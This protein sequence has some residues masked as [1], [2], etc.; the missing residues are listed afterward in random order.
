MAKACKYRLPGQETWMSEDDFKKS[1]A[2]GLLDKFILD[3]KASIPSLRGFK[4]DA[5]A[6]QKFRATVTEAAPTETPQAEE[7]KYFIDG[8]EVSKEEA[9][10]EIQDESRR[11]DFNLSGRK[12]EYQGTNEQAAR[13]IEEHNKSISPLNKEGKLKPN[14]IDA[15]IKKAFDSV[16]FRK[17]GDAYRRHIDANFKQTNNETRVGGVIGGKKGMSWNELAGY[18]I[19]DGQ[20]LATEEQFRAFAKELGL[21]VPTQ[22]TQ[23]KTETT[24]VTETKAEPTAKT[25]PKKKSPIDEELD[26]AI[27]DM[28][29]IQEEIDIEKDN[30]REEKERIKE[31]KAKVRA[32][33]MPKAEK[34]DKL[35]D[36]DAELQDYIDNAEGTIE[37]LQYDLRAAKSE[38]KKIENRKSK[39]ESTTKEETT[40]R[41]NIKR[42]SVKLTQGQVN[43][44]KR[45][46]IF[47]KYFSDSQIENLKEGDNVLSMNNVSFGNF[48]RMGIGEV[49]D[50]TEQ[51]TTKTTEPTTK[52]EPKPTT[53]KVERKGFVEVEAETKRGTKT[54]YM[55]EVSENGKTATIKPTY[56]PAFGGIA[57]NKEIPNLPISVDSKGNRY[58]QTKGET[59]VYIDKVKEAPK[60]KE[61]PVKE[62]VQGKGQPTKVKIFAR[63]PKLDD[64]GMPIISKFNQ[65]VEFTKNKRTGKWETTDKAGNK[66]EATEEQ[67]ARADKALAEQPKKTTKQKISDAFDSLKIDTKGK[68]LSI[69]IPPGIYNDIIEGAKQLVLKGI[70]IASAIKQAT[71]KALAARK[72]AD[73]V[74]KNVN[75]YTNSKEFTDKINE[76]IEGEERVSGIKKGL[77]SQESKELSEDKLNRMS[78]QEALDAGEKAIKDGTIDPEKIINSIASGSGKRLTPIETVAMSYYKVSLDND[79]ANAYEQLNKAVIDKD[80]FAEGD[81]RANIKLA[82]EKIMNYEIMSNIT[83]YEDG[84]TLRLRRVMLNSEYNLVKIR[85]KITAE[86]KGK[87]P[88]EV[89]E[90]LKDLD[91]KFRKVSA[92]LEKLKK[93]YDSEKSEDVINSIKNIKET[94]EKTSSISNDAKIK[95]PNSLIKEA[96]DKGAKEIEDVIDYVRDYVKSKYQDATDRQIRDAITNYSKTYKSPSDAQLDISRIKRIGRLLSNLEDLQ[97]GIKKTK[98]ERKKQA[99]SIREKELK[100]AIKEQLAKLPLTE[101]EI[102]KIQEDKLQSFKDRMQKSIEDLQRKLDKGD[103]TKKTN[104]KLIDLDEEARRLNAER[105]EIKFQYDKEFELAQKKNRPWTQ[106]LVEAYSKAIKLPRALITSIDLGAPFMQGIVF[107]LTQNP[108]TTYK[109]I[110]NQFKFW[111]NENAYKEWMN[112]LKSSEYYPLMKA[113]GL[114]IAEENA[115]LSAAEEAFMS[116]FQHKIPFLGKEIK[117]KSGRRIVPGLDLYGR[118]ERGY[119]GFLNNLRVQVFL[120]GAEKLTDLG[121][122]PKTNIKEFKSWADYV[123]NATMRGT[124]GDNVF[125]RGFNAS[126]PALANIFFSPRMIKGTINTLGLDPSM[127]IRLS[128]QAR[129]MAIKRTAAFYGMAAT[130]IGIAALALNYDDDDKASVELDMRSSDF[131]KIKYGNTRINFLGPVLPYFVA[132]TKFA[133]NSEKN[134]KTKEIEE[135]GIKY[136]GKTRGKVITNLFSNKLS[137]ITKKLYDAAYLTEAEKEMRLEEGKTEASQIFSDM[138]IPLFLQDV[139]ELNEEHGFYGATGLTILA[140]M[141]IGIQNFDNKYK[142]SKSSYLIDD[143]FEKEMDEFDKFEEQEQK[144][145]EGF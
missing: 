80:V 120:D 138:T 72:L 1:L 8:K 40:P 133:T 3:D 128:P 129:K 81:A 77:T 49:T 95:V 96:V 65:E 136:G 57:D 100:E 134:I 70:D 25:E 118:S 76:A 109:H 24:P 34:Q 125:G 73:D 48:K 88:K 145:L 38:V 9:I 141:G 66:I 19:G 5:T 104:K 26:R 107:T 39:A 74:I 55:A 46:P 20:N 44:I 93:Q 22:T 144:L 140:F 21:E 92:E 17:F 31:E 132:L 60:A 11:Y 117:T 86:Y 10:K 97:K 112:Q 114:Y 47:K 16:S 50:I 15:A 87:L 113:S 33:K 41:R 106:V 43:T 45:T 131:G 122:S 58:V 137:P 14:Y 124:G 142:P 119:I 83:G 2:D 94:K 75:D 6:A 90:R 52:A 89:E 35:E 53:E 130:T 63:E 127:Y 143:E 56:D 105:E 111:K 28:E 71:S 123:N 54:T 69:P 115:K 79:L 98:N 29:N 78:V 116:D 99:L 110:K 85:N 62:E 27:I 67:A 139:G 102:N 103:F 30:I 18:I 12:I 135:L 126:A 4:A 42:V 61:A 37:N 13:E 64:R 23:T 51:T 32:S 108:K 36:L 7:G 68:T 91:S 101:E 121:F 82:E 84:L 59:R